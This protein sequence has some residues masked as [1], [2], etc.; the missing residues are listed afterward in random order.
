MCT[1][2]LE[3]AVPRPVQLWI[4]R[5]SIKLLICLAAFLNGK[6]KKRSD[7]VNK[8]FVGQR[9]HFWRR[10]VFFR[11]QKYQGYGCFAEINIRES[12]DIM[13]KNECRKIC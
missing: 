6:E 12:I 10:I 9:R 8:L 11:F 1:A 4:R 5:A 2:G 3:T 7:S 13:K